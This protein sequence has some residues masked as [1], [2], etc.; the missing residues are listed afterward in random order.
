MFKTI[1]DA[2]DRIYT[3]ITPAAWRAL[4]PRY[5]W[6]GGLAI[7]VALWIVTGLL[8]TKAKPIEDDTAAPTGLPR[9]SV[10]TLVA[11]ERDA[12]VTVRLRA[13]GIPAKR[14]DGVVYVRNSD[15]VPALYW[16]EWVEAWVGEWTQLDPTFDQVVADATHLQLGEEG[17]AEITPLIGALKV[18]DVK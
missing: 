7:V 14:V 17:S 3:T 13:A 16:H 6:A 1:G 18:E 4:K 15:G 2:L 11:V 12:T 5:Q 9:V 8:G 10:A